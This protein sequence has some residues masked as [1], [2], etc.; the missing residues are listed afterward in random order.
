MVEKIETLVPIVDITKYVKD[1]KTLHYIE[2]YDGGQDE[3]LEDRILKHEA[4]ENKMAAI[5]EGV[6]EFVKWYNEQKNKAST[7]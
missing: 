2:F 7:K 6:V 3:I 4:G 5:F 1:G